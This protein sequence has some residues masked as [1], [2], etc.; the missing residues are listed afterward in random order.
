MTASYFQKWKNKTGNKKLFWQRHE[1]KG[2][3]Q[4]PGIRKNAGIFCVPVLKKV[5]PMPESML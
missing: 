4:D 5:F 1:A 2:L 3:N